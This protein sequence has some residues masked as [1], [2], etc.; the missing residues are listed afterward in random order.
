MSIE[1]YD[2]CMCHLTYDTWSRRP[3]TKPNAATMD[4]VRD[5][6]ILVNA[7]CSNDFSTLSWYYKAIPDKSIV[8]DNCTFVLEYVRYDPEIIHKWARLKNEW[9]AKHPRD[10]FV[11]KWPGEYS[12]QS[13]K[14]SA[15]YMDKT[16]FYESRQRVKVLEEIRRT[17]DAQE[18]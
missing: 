11:E 3:P 1:P 9:I 14:G 4:K 12:Y 17:S 18:K 5:C 7:Q 15:V 10:K 2:D 16:E 6:L 13:Y 8:V